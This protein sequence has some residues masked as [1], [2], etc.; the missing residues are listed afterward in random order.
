MNSWIA[1]GCR[2]ALRLVLSAA[3]DQVEVPAVQVARAAADLRRHHTPTMGVEHLALESVPRAHLHLTE[4]L[5]TLLLHRRHPRLTVLKLARGAV[6]PTI[7]TAS[8]A[9]RNL[10]AM[11]FL[12]M[13]TANHELRRRRGTG[14]R[15]SLAI[16]LTALSSRA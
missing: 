8:L 12:L 5:G 6:P 15:R 14:H 4:A 10:G 2:A 11:P 13:E 3:R 9:A 16:V 1:R 7:P